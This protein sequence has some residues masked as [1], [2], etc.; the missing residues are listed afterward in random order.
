LLHHFQGQKVKGQLAG[1]GAYC[2]ETTFVCKCQVVR[3]CL[4]FIRLG[5][6][7]RQ[8]WIEYMITIS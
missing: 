6:S 4:K 2:D 5:F 7:S 3:S 1:G 8:N